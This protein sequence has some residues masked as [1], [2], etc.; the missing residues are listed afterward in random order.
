M[1]GRKKLAIFLGATV[2][3]LVLVLVFALTSGDRPGQAQLS[4]EL[5]EDLAKENVPDDVQLELRAGQG[6]EEAI[7]I[8][9]RKL[10]AGV[11]VEKDQVCAGEDVLIKPA[12][13]DV[14]A[15][16][17]FRVNLRSRGDQAILTFKEPGKRKLY[18][19]AGDGRFGVDFATASI[20]VLP[21]D[22]PNCAGKPRLTLGSRV[23]R[24]QPDSADIE[25]VE[26]K[27]L[28]QNLTYTWDFGD[29]T[30]SQGTEKFATHSYLHRDQDK[31]SSTFVV[32]VTAQDTS[33]KQ[34]V[35]RT[36]ITF[37]NTY[38][39]ARITG[40]PA[41]PVTYDRFPKKDGGG[42][43]TTIS[44]RNIER[45]SIALATAVVKV[46]T[47]REGA[48]VEAKNVP[49]TSLIATTNLP[50]RQTVN[51]TLTLP[52]TV[53]GSGGACRAEITF[54]GDTVPGRQGQPVGPDLPAR[55]TET[56]ATVF[57][58]LD[59]PPD[60]EKGGM[61]SSAPITIRDEKTLEKLK[62]ARAIL[63]RDHVTPQDVLELEKQGK[64]K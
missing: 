18:V 8:K 28:G 49:I 29:G 54:S 33:G 57:L 47:C 21:E 19:T 26:S 46:H 1:A 61:A 51:Q 48:Q 16:V 7:V 15:P 12:Q 36:S 60:K 45:T 14:N 62:K 50:P 27:G 24:F 3:V 34:A 40:A 42:Y 35:A 13:T 44:F 56:T 43:R 10:I 20:E 23:S 55:F 39:L 17:Q 41:I 2:L 11:N 58:E 59:A 25:V 4:P 63:G 31:P 52:G 22:H 32:K 5:K 9:R 37:N 6:G 64:L 38:F 53:L 30:S